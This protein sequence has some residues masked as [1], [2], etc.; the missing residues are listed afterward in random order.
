M[1]GV[2]ASRSAPKACTVVLGLFLFCITN[3]SSDPSGPPDV[4]AVPHLVAMATEDMANKLHKLLAAPEAGLGRQDSEG[5]LAGYFSVPGAAVPTPA[6]AALGRLSERLH[7]SSSDISHWVTESQAN[8]AAEAATVAN[9]HRRSSSDAERLRK[10]LQQVKTAAAKR[11]AAAGPEIDA[12]EAREQHLREQLIART[13]AKTPQHAAGQAKSAQHAK[14]KTVSSGAKATL[15]KLVP[16]RVGRKAQP[17]E[18]K[19]AGHMSS[20][21]KQWLS[22]SARHKVSAAHSAVTA[23]P[24]PTVAP[25]AFDANAPKRETSGLPEYIEDPHLSNAER[26]F[27]LAKAD[28]ARAKEARREA[29]QM[30]DLREAWRKNGRPHDIP[31]DQAST[32]PTGRWSKP[33]SHLREAAALMRK[34]KDGLREHLHQ[35]HSSGQR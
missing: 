19:Q 26:M 3:A 23:G 21:L 7:A 30:E 16:R 2:P 15:R 33:N 17:R 22:E 24:A 18:P 35:G 27:T 6:S 34:A 10:A 14:V 29:R 20:N 9:G 31:S 8:Y 4:G 32:K 1:M 12:L 28:A 11:A 13:P 25:S 5:A